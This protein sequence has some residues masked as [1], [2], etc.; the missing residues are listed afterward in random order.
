MATKF[1]AGFLRAIVP[2]GTSRKL[3]VFFKESGWSDSSLF[4]T[5]CHSIED[6]ISV[7]RDGPP[8]SEGSSESKDRCYQPFAGA[9]HFPSFRNKSVASSGLFPNAAV[10]NSHWVVSEGFDFL[11]YRRFWSDVFSTD[12]KIFVVT[13]D[14]WTETLNK[15]LETIEVMLKRYRV[16]CGDFILLL[17]CSGD[18]GSSPGTG[19]DKYI[20]WVNDSFG[21][22]RLSSYAT[23]K[24][25]DESLYERWETLF[26]ELLLDDRVASMLAKSDLASRQSYSSH[27]ENLISTISVCDPKKYEKCC[28]Q[29]KYLKNTGE[30][31]TYVVGLK[32]VCSSLYNR[33]GGD[34]IVCLLSQKTDVAI[35]NNVCK[36]NFDELYLRAIYF[37]ARF[38]IDKAIEINLGSEQLYRKLGSSFVR[39][40]RIGT[41][42]ERSSK[43]L[44][45]RYE[46]NY[47]VYEI[48]PKSMDSIK[49]E[50]LGCVGA[51]TRHIEGR[52]NASLSSSSEARI[53]KFPPL[54]MYSRVPLS[55]VA[56]DD[57]DYAAGLWINSV[58]T[59]SHS[60]IRVVEL[61]LVRVCDN[62]TN[63]YFKED[64]DYKY[65]DSICD[66]YHYFKV[67]G[68]V[69]TKE[70]LEE[71]PVAWLLPRFGNGN[72]YHSLI[73]KLPALYGYKILGLD[74][75]IISA[76]ELD[77]TEKSLLDAV[78]ISYQKVRVDV[79]ARFEIR[80]GYIPDISTFRIPFIRYCSAFKDKVAD[81]R[82]YISRSRASLRKME[83]EAAVEALMERFG[84]RVVHMENY[85]FAEQVEIAASASCIAG[86]HGAGLS[87]MI[88]MNEG[89]HVLELIPNKYMTPLFKQLSVD[90]GHKYSVLVGKEGSDTNVKNDSI[91]GDLIW[92]VDLT[93]LELIL[94]DLEASLPQDVL[95]TS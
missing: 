91:G 74:C 87:N 35:S 79:E 67:T 37:I 78:G 18:S 61:P 85:S 77:E 6:V 69:A 15:C 36:K 8:T 29:V 83:N 52:D 9:I 40:N 4:S 47:K 43:L 5:G 94:W 50:L 30:L 20:A 65:V 38:D 62:P 90:C 72:Y 10:A 57:S 75:P 32:S 42:L 21:I 64:N 2:L 73:D 63:I 59:N 3:G 53:L 23:K 71:I 26:Y 13:A 48:L 58:N 12:F 89:S 66:L 80:L 31:H 25:Q 45:D 41:A 86:P 81:Q 33:V 84:F 39:Y 24:W 19:A 82:I 46:H 55:G 14:V 68:R 56:C 1:D 7:L 54:C 34:L 70:P 76:Y 11:Q 93:R 16:D 88:F 27:V 28:H 17:V 60:E 95:A 51:A 22:A 44:S 49:S 92:R